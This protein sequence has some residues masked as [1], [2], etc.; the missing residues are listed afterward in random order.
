VDG[1]NFSSIETVAAAGNST[2]KIDYHYTDMYPPAGVIYYRLKQVDLDGRAN[3]STL[4]AVNITDD[5]KLFIRPNPVQHSA[6]I[7]FLCEEGGETIIKIYDALGQ[8]VYSKKTICTNG[9]NSEVID[10]T[11]LTK[12]IY[13]VK[14]KTGDQE[15][16]RRFL[17]E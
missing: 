16:K 6:E 14:V 9:K 17:K 5:N 10:L 15:L 13:F 1:M 2:E 4:V 11:L 7:G 8:E 12:G 3:Y